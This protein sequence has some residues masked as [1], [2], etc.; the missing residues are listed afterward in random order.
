MKILGHGNGTKIYKNLAPVDPKLTYFTTSSMEHRKWKQD[1]VWQFWVMETL[2][3]STK[4]L[5]L[6][7]Q[8]WRFSLHTGMKHRKWKQDLV[9]QFWVMETLLKSTNTWPLSTQSWRFSL[10]TGKEHRQW[11]QD[12]VWQFWVMETVLKSTKHG[13]CRPKVDVFHCIRAWNIGSENKT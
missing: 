6:S 5:P 9:V 1:L 3:K 12:L 2:L 4:T 13:P 11:K 8:S 10:H 7:T